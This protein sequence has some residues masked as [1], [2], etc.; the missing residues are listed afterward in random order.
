MKDTYNWEKP[1]Q[2]EN[3]G[4]QNPDKEN[5]YGTDNPRIKFDEREDPLE[6]NRINKEGSPMGQTFNDVEGIVTDEDADQVKSHEERWWTDS[7]DIEKDFLDTL[8]DEN[9]SQ[10]IIPNSP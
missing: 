3:L 8:I 4:L 9:A 10:E 6:I 1:D 5:T 2:R 7:E